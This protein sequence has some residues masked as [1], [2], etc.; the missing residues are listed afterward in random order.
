MILSILSALAF[1]LGISLLSFGIIFGYRTF[2]GDSAFDNPLIPMGVS[3][4]FSTVGLS[5]LYGVIG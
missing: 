1:G 2:F 4:I 5:L 3:F